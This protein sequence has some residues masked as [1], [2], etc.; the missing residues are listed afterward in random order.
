MY[1]YAY[2]LSGEEAITS[3]W[4]TA[5]KSARLKRVELSCSRNAPFIA[6]PDMIKMAEL[7]EIEV[8]S[9]H[10]PFGVDTEMGFGS[11]GERLEHVNF[12]AG[13]LN[14]CAPFKCRNFTMH[15]GP[16]RSEQ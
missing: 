5:N 14:Q 9:I 13:F 16:E 10:I 7:K 1:R 12:I 3:D 6:I 15:S 8:A 2:S 11:A 4:Q